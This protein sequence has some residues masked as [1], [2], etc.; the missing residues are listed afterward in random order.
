ME[1]KNHTISDQWEFIL[2]VR[3]RVGAEGGGG[4]PAGGTGGRR[5][6]S[7]SLSGKYQGSSAPMCS[8]FCVSS[9]R[10][11]SVNGFAALVFCAFT[12]MPPHAAVI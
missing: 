12:L 3:P 9:T 5:V 7:F 11:S 6:W 4:L 1:K 8:F 2:V 10:V